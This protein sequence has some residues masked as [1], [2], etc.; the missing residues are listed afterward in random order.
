M[1][2]NWA[3]ELAPEGIHA[4]VLCPG[5]TQTRINESE[6]NK[7]D[8]YRD[9]SAG[10]SS[11][12]SA[13]ESVL[14]RVVEQGLPSNVVAERVVEALESKELYVFTHPSYKPLAEV[15]FKAASAAFESAAQSPVL[16]DYVNLP[17][18]DFS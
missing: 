12:A 8:R 2:E 3:H 6:R 13:M 10:G 11:A 16:A 5:F 1:T 14:K 9:E 17:L 15:R 18:P 4:C 7:P